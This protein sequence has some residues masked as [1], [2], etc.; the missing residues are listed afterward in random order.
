MKLK[1]T[2]YYLFFLSVLFFHSTV[3]AQNQ[4]MQFDHLTEEDGLTFSTV[5]SIIQD[6][7]G[8]MW[9]GTFKGL[10]RYDGYEMKTYIHQEGNDFGPHDDMISSIIQDHS[11]KLWIGLLNNGLSIF[12]P[13]SETFK[14]LK[15]GHDPEN[16]VPSTSVNSLLEDSDNNIW[17]AS[18]NGLSIV[19]F[20]RSKFKKYYHKEG[21]INSINHNSVYDIVEDRWNRVWLATGNRKLS[22]YDKNTKKF[23]EVEYTDLPLE[24]VED[25]DKKNL[26]IYQDTLLYIGSNNGGLSEYNLLTGE[27]TSYL[28]SDDNT[29]PS[30]NNIRDMLEVD[31]KVWIATDGAG[32]N[33]FDVKTKTFEV[34]KNEKSKPESLSSDVIWSL[35]RDNQKNIWLGIYLQGVDKYDSQKNYFRLVGNTPC[36]NNALPNKPVLA[37]YNDSKGQRWVGTDWGGLHKM[38][39]NEQHFYHYDIDGSQLQDDYAVDVCKSIAEDKYG[40]LLVGTYSQGLRIYDHKTGKQSNIKRTDSNSSIPSNHIWD[41]MTDSRGVTWLGTLGGGIATFDP[42]T[43]DIKALPLNYTNNAQKHVY[44]IMEDS[45][46]K[47]WFSTDGGAVYYDPQSNQWN[48]SVIQEFLDKDHSFHYVKAII[49]DKYRHIWIGTAAGLIKYKPESKHFEVLD[50]SNGIPDLPILNLASDVNGDIILSTKKYISKVLL[51]GNKIVSYYI[52]NNSFNYNAVIAM[53]NHEIGIGGT[54]GITVFDPRELKENQNIPPVYVTDF[55]LFNVPQRPTDSTSYLK[56]NVTE[57]DLITLDHDQS[58]INFKYCGINYSETERNQYA[59]KLEGFD[60]QWN[61]V[62]DRRMATY[63]NL[64]PGQYTFKVIASNNHGV[65]NKEGTSLELIIKTPFWQSL[66]FRALMLIGF[67]L[68]LYLVQRVRIINVKR[69]FVFDKIRAEREKIQVHNEK[70]EQ[71]LT[72]IKSELENITI[73]HLHKNQSLQQ[74]RTKLE[75]ISKGLSTAEQRKIRSLVRDINKE[76]ED[77]DYWDKFEHQFNKSHNNFLERFS[78]E[79]PDLS[80]RELRICAYLRMDLDNQEIAT[81]MNVSVRTLETSRYRIR[82]K[83]GLENRK[84]LT[85]MIT[86]F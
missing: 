50:K 42:D 24:S 54:D 83:I 47:I 75:D 21:E 74:I 23:T 30:S 63:T 85:K 70:L 12:D 10:N 40:N 37:L 84:S 66:W 27:H 49:E 60:E 35:Y 71:E 46:G 52:S 80:K 28:A 61:Y 5:T 17:I 64:D 34:Y 3:I 69:Q 20:D 2:S 53:D 15:G 6:N 67:L 16:I 1:T 22:M 68:L 4:I 76:S 86:R 56:E 9:F 45:Y 29:G 18:S 65:W 19:N 77:H 59:Y 11:G 25:N 58:V 81:L 33:V 44:H 26:C 41:I 82:K 48:F 31:G 32:L 78:K 73:S 8:F 36:D 51:N 62:G 72:S 55:E 57:I 14:H 7:Q 39:E 38:S 79:Y 43:K 13:K